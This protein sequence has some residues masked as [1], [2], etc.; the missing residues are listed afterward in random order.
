MTPEKDAQ[1]LRAYLDDL[2][3]EIREL[4]EKEL[5]RFRATIERCCL[6]WGL[7]KVPAARKPRL[8]ATEKN[9][10][11][12]SPKRIYRGP[13]SMHLAMER[14]SDEQRRA[15]RR[16]MER[17][18]KFRNT[19]DPAVYWS[20]GKRSLLEIA[21]LVRQEVGQMDLKFL[22]GYFETLEKYGLIKMERTG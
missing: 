13:I 12:I 2:E 21:K 1:A 5:D 4:A 6:S 3:A 7:K 8:T 17:K 10:A 18:K 16:E 14:M 9:A 15:Y 22:L 11:K 20:D 19:L